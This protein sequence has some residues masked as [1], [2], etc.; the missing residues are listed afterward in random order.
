M[1]CN[2]STDPR[3]LNS[4]VTCAKDFIQLDVEL[5]S[6]LWQKVQ[7]KLEMHLIDKN[8]KPFYINKTHVYIRTSLYDCGTKLEVTKDHVTFTNSFIVRE[9]TGAGQLVSFI[10]DVE[11]DF[12]C[13]YARKNATR[14]TGITQE[15][16]NKKCF[17]ITYLGHLC[18]LISALEVA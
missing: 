2:L 15:K 6:K 8:C 12:R 16:A 4:H 13:I 14:K 17:K 1:Y 3:F 7:T 11:V 18:R 5:N 9:E 10:P